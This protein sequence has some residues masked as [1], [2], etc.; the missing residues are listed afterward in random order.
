MYTQTI[1]Y[2][3]SRHSRDIISHVPRLYDQD[4]YRLD[5]DEDDEERIDI[6]QADA[7]EAYPYA[8]VHIE[9]V[10][11]TEIL[12]HSDQPLTFGSRSFGTAHISR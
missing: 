8:D 3:D 10:F 7:A 9:S 11:G 2:G 1:I 6:A 12:I 4:G 5:S